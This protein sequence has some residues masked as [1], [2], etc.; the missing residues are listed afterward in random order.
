MNPSQIKKN[1]RLIPAAYEPEFEAPES[2]GLI[3]AE[4]PP[5]PRRRKPSVGSVRFAWLGAGHCGGRILAAFRALGYGKT[6]AV[7]TTRR[8]LDRLEIPASHK[9]LLDIG[10][11]G[12]G[13]DMSLGRKAVQSH[14]AK[15]LERM[16]KSF[17][18]DTDH[19]M[20]CFGAGGGTGGGAAPELIALAR[21]YARQIG[22]Q[23]SGKSIGVIMT[24]PTA[25][26]AASPTV[27][28]NACMVAGELSLMARRGEISPLVI[29]D[30][31][32]V[33]PTGSNLTVK[34]YWPT[35]NQRI[36]ELFDVFNRLSFQPSE[37]TAFDP[38]DY[39]SILSAGGCAAM[40][41]CEVRNLDDR[42]CISRAVRTRLDQSLLAGSFDLSSAR[43][44]GCAVVGGKNQFAEIPGLP[45]TIH[46][47]F[48]SIAQVAPG[49]TLHRGIYEDDTEVLRVY[50]LIGGLEAPA[51][52]L[53]RLTR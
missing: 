33:C 19:I 43:I 7:N 16:H 13:K 48:D 50:T 25:G 31:D 32:R 20:I 24:L 46:Y 29:I 45:E 5:R 39:Y 51:T 47:A 37:Y 1:R 2:I 22:L 15:I 28:R 3:P 52:L 23:R 35:V 18:G 10:I 42:N 12:A 30:N 34:S 26:E 53:R 38:A 6:L 49:A 36:A 44:I 14:Q 27:A 41:A 9:M 8:D 40:G 17:G 4:A 11:E 21:S